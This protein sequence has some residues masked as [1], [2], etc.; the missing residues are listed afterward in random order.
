[1]PGSRLPRGKNPTGGKSPRVSYRRCPF[2][3]WSFSGDGS[4]FDLRG[5]ASPARSATS[6]G[7]ACLGAVSLLIGV[8]MALL[9]ERP[10]SHASG[11][12]NGNIRRVINSNKSCPTS[13]ITTVDE[14][15]YL[16]PTPPSPRHLV[17]HL[18]SKLSF[19]FVRAVYF[20]SSYPRDRRHVL[21]EYGSYAT[22]SS[23]VRCKEK[24]WHVGSV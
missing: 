5:A 3:D 11:Y 20:A 12:H 9:E 14:T 4:L 22:G 17:T 8:R 24:S 13:D 21:N 1:M 15:L 18:S 10:R 7:R 16:P 2:E 23:S 19:G 6:F